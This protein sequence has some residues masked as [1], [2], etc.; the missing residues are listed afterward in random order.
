MKKLAV[1]SLG[2]AKNLVDTERAVSALLN[3]GLEMS[4]GPE[5]CDVILINT[6]S[7][8][9]PARKEA[10]EVFVEIAQSAKPDAKVIVA[11]CYAQMI[12]ERIFELFPRANALL[13]TGHYKRA[14]EALEAIE[15]GE[16]PVWTGDPGV[17]LADNYDRT[18]LTAPHFAYL[19][20]ADGCGHT[21]T[22]CVIPRLRGPYRSR[23]I[24]DIVE[25]AK[26]LADL[27]VVELNL[28]AQDTT[29]YGQDLPGKPTLADLLGE[30]EDCGARWIRINYMHPDRLDDSLIDYIAS[31]HTVLPYFDI[32][33]QHASPRILKLMGRTPNEPEV[34]VQRLMRIREIIPDATL[35]TSL[36]AGFPGETDDDFNRNIWLLE[37]VRFD[38]AGIFEYSDEEGTPASRLPD[39]VDPAVITERAE[40]LNGVQAAIAAEMNRERKG[41]RDEFIVDILL[42]GAALGRVRGQ[43]PEVDPYAYAYGCPDHTEPGDIIPVE[44]TSHQG[45]ELIAE[46]RGND[47]D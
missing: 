19:K 16:R 17:G 3:S 18:L 21:C 26:A 45:Y 36:I 6:C 30:L 5:D 28:L 24:A 8:I 39:K 7:F 32:P 42:E 47:D 37:E 9:A 2:C 23:Q 4:E 10:V 43:A 38:Y 46:Y 40:F 12:G 31:S 27:G 13:G 22:F 20:I 25:E 41:T 35:R 15:K 34:V 1:I 33:L 14:A 11:G 44:I 29:N